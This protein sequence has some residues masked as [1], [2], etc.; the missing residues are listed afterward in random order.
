MLVRYG[1]ATEIRGG[2]H[3]RGQCRTVRYSCYLGRNHECRAQERCCEICQQI[4]IAKGSG[5]QFIG[6]ATAHRLHKVP[7]VRGLHRNT[8]RGCASVR[9]ATYRS[10]AATDLSESDRVLTAALRA[11]D[12]V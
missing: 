10:K 11:S 7:P 4:P 6:E 8:I 2:T 1:N 9:A 12:E 3:N 5:R